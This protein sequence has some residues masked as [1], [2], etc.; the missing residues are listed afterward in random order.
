[1]KYGNISLDGILNTRAGTDSTNPEAPAG[2]SFNVTT[3]SS[4]TS[5]G[6]PINLTV[7]NGTPDGVINLSTVSASASPLLNFKVGSY[8]TSL[9]APA[10]T[11]N[12]QFVFPTTTGSTGQYLVTSSTGGQTGW[13]T[14]GSSDI[15]NA[16]GYTPVNQTFVGFG[17]DANKGAAGTYGRLYITTDTGK[18][19]YDSGTAW[20]AEVPA[21]SGDVT[22]SV[23]STVLT[24]AASGVT[25]GT[26]TKVTVN[27]KG[28]V[29]AGTSLTSSDVTSAL[30]YTP[31]QQGSGGSGTTYSGGTGI[32]ISGSTINI[33]N[34]GT[35]TGTFGSSV[36]TPVFTV[37]A[38]GQITS[39]STTTTAPQW[40]AIAGKPSTLSG[41]GI[42]DGLTTST[43]FGG[44][45][46][47]PYN[48]LQLANSGAPNGSGFN[49]F[50][51][52]SQ[53]LITAAST[54]AYLTQ[55][56]TINVN[57]DVTGSGTTNL[58]LNLATTGV[59]AGTYTKLTVNAKGLV[60]SASALASSD[61]TSILGYTPLNSANFLNGQNTMTEGNYSSIPGSST[62]GNLYVASDNRT[63]W[64]YN[65]GW[66]PLSKVLN[67]Y[68]T[69]VPLTTTTATLALSN[70]APNNSV[71]L[72]LINQT[73]SPVLTTSKIH[74]Y[75]SLSATSSIA[76]AT[77]IVM[78][79]RGSTLIGTFTQYCAIAQAMQNI[80][81]SVFD[82]P[83]ST[84]SQSYTIRIA[85]TAGTTYIGQNSSYN[86][87]FGSSANLSDVM[88]VE[89]V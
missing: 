9:S 40:S 17:T 52:N 62:T 32:T 43:N 37:N 70:S 24:L 41:F 82:S 14:L 4:T 15:L 1:M 53:G 26:Y 78:I 34:T 8:T 33:S 56:Q 61:I 69:T 84:S 51:V 31:A 67:Y 76:G 72:Q 3:G 6:G 28:L 68:S 44:S 73:I 79:F 19:Y 25:A 88:F 80:A 2:E 36:L 77:I 54:V 12:T 21:Y 55:N 22:S 47:G 57:G 46:T 13:K 75:G 89:M 66:T 58:T 16:L 27:A 65:G 81:F 74:I 20:I 23:N 49:T 11:A 59:V 35:G 42:T 39:V 7:G 18:I 85:S 87:L 71:G 30:G 63:I 60:T 86:T 10:L 29:T 50:S 83:A 5:N 45:V 64:Y 48:N 38:Q